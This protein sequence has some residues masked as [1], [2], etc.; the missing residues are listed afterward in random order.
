MSLVASAHMRMKK[1]KDKPLSPANNV[2]VG[3]R[4]I[5]SPRNGGGAEA[6]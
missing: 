2:A 6:E 4:P 5:V 3:G 1:K